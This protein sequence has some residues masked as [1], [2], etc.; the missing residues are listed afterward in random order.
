[1][2]TAIYEMIHY[3][4]LSLDRH[5]IK[6]VD[7]SIQIWNRLK[8]HNSQKQKV[9]FSGRKNSS[10]TQKT[11]FFCGQQASQTD[12]SKRGIDVFPVRTKDFQ[13]N[14]EKICWERNDSCSTNVL[15]RIQFVQDLH[16]T[17]AVYHQK[18]SVNFRTGKS[19]P[20]PTPNIT[21]V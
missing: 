1:M 13:I 5:C 19:L 2:N 20:S 8:E 10:R 4:V 9:V 7:E 14:I 6:I 11:A 21:E 18:C 16:A 17:D 15:S 12:T 3:Y